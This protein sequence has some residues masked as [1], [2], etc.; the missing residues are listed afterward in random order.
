M[1]HELAR[2]DVPKAVQCYMSDTG[3]TE[4]EA[5]AHMKVLMRKLWRQMNKCRLQDTPLS[6]PVV[7]Y[8]FDLLR[9]TH[10]TYR[11]GD[12]FSVQHEGK[13]K[14]LLNALIVEPIPL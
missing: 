9:A 1:Q 2:G 5:H 6:L 8:I 14:Y 4:E 12:G 7:D 11:D 3:C 10:Y 13:S